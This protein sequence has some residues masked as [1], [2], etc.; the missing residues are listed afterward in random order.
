[1]PKWCKSE[2]E[3]ALKEIEGSKMSVNSTAKKFGISQ[4][5]LCMITS[6]RK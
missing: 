3:T 4:F 2:L 5:P 1:M 6:E